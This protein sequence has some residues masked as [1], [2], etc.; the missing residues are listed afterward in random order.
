MSA[1][2]D[3]M[4][5]REAASEILGGISPQRVHQLVATYGIETLQ[6][7]PRVLLLKKAD[8]ARVAQKERLSGVHIDHQRQRRRKS[9]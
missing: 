1:L 8:V 7:S 4:T 3:W 5:V 2:K 9:T 6:P